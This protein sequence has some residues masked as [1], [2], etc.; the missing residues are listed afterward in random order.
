[1]RG[2]NV[3]TFNHATMNEVVEHYLRTVL[4][5]NN[6]IEVVSVLSIASG[7]QVR[8]EMGKLQS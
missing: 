7:F 6:L 4:M 1:V 2:V 5:K 8:F 3:I